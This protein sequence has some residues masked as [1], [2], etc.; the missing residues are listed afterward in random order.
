MD[1]TS[2]KSSKTEQT[3][4]FH[5]TQYFEAPLWPPFVVCAAGRPHFYF[6]KGSFPCLHHRQKAS[7]FIKKTAILI[8]I[9]NRCFENKHRYLSAV[10][11][12]FSF[13]VAQ[14]IFHDFF[15]ITL[16]LQFIDSFSNRHLAYPFRRRT[17]CN[18]NRNE[19]KENNNGNQYDW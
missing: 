16:L 13:A 17:N 19:I 15:K 10:R 8:F 3:A 4:L 12:L 9:K 14:H 2:L 5:C 18:Q 1:S 7:F 6:Y 11:Q